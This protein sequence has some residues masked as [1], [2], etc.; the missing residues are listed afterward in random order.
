MKYQQRLK[1]IREKSDR[2][3]NEMELRDD[4]PSVEELRIVLCLVSSHLL[5]TVVGTPGLPRS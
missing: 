1:H 2:M 3:L 4:V 5:Q